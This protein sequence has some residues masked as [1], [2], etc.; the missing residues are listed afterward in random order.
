VRQGRPAAADKPRCYG[1][2][3]AEKGKTITMAETFTV[4]EGATGLALSI[5]IG[6]A[7]PAYLMFR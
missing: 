3:R 6:G 2:A 1:L 4:P 5:T 7:R